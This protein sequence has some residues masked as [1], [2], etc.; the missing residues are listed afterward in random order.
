MTWEEIQAIFSAMRPADFSGMVTKGSQGT[1]LEL[2]SW[3]TNLDIDTKQHKFSWQ[4]EEYTLTLNSTGEYDLS[5]L[6]PD[7]SRLY[8]VVG[9]AIGGRSPIYRDLYSFNVENGG[10]QMSMRG[11][12]LLLSGATSGTVKIVYYSKY[13]VKNS[14]GTR[15]ARFTDNTDVT[16]I[17]NPMVLI[18]GMLK[19]VYARTTGTNNVG[20]L[21]REARA[22]YNLGIQDLILNDQTL[23]NAVIDVRQ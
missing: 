20:E 10:S 19:Y 1:D 18:D 14:G 9:D 23:T 13:Y 3:L 21:V 12:T 4:L 11:N 22:N 2:Y 17:P 15:K 7:F 6:I 16:T 8:Q 5:T